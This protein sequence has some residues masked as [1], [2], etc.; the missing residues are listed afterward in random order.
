MDQSNFN[1][2]LNFDKM[3]T[4]K[5]IIYI[6]VISSIIY[7]I[8]GFVLIVNSFSEES[9]LD[10]FAGV[11]FIILGPF[12]SRIFSE[13]LLIQFKIFERL[14]SIDEKLDRNV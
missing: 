8:F 14:K 9:F 12:L 11:G 13:I 3:I 6:F 1:Q 7:I 4:P 10:F 2:F 5:V